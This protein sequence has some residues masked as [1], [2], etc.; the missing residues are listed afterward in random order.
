MIIDTDKKATVDPAMDGTTDVT[1]GDVTD[2]D[3]HF[4][5]TFSFGQI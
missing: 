3:V 1:D 5:S 2:G 4:L